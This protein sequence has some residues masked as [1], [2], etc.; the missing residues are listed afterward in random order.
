MMRGKCKLWLF[1]LTLLAGLGLAAQ[2]AAA[3]E[4]LAI[5]GGL[6]LPMNG[7][8]IENGIILIRHGK[9]EA[10]GKD[11]TIPPEVKVIDAKGKVIMPGFIEAHS[12]RGMDQVNENN[13]NTP[14]LSVLDSIDPSQDYF[15]ECR[16]NGVT[17]VAILPGHNTMFGGQGAIVK[18]AGP[19]VNEMVIKRGAGIKISLKPTADRSRMSHLAA[20]RKELDAARIY[21]EEEKA[22]QSPKP[23]TKAAASA[24]EPAD[25]NTTVVDGFQRPQRGQ[26]GNAPRGD[27][28]SVD[29]A[30]VRA[31]LASLLKGEVPAYIYCELAMDVPQ[32][33]RLTK[34]YGLKTIL[35]LD[36]DCYKAAKL[37]AAS[38]LPVILEPTLVFWDTNPRTGEDEQINLVEIYRSEKV[39]F[40]VQATGFSS[41]N[42]FRQPNLP[43]TLGTN[44]LWYQAATLVKYGTPVHEALKLITSGAAQT[45][46]VDKIVGT[47][48]KGKD[49]DLIILTGDPLKID[50]WVDKTIING[51]V[52]YD[53]EQD[54]K[55]KQLLQSDA[56]K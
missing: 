12:S 52:V 27:G 17:T 28:G 14:F 8:P 54:R 33:L 18:T 43:P 41:G 16:R 21:L 36:K 37:V 30:Q 56:K 4:S 50:T 48:E 7:P 2:P 22:K 29:A 19:T 5:R 31:A 9:I 11:V 38:G 20:L 24:Q 3:Q 10:I 1:G 45:I 49:A 15:D 40:H 46:G 13:P 53:R 47:L 44:Y 51:S 35:V 6:I 25:D 26:R 23:T 32:A 55:L 34:E 42:L 39:P